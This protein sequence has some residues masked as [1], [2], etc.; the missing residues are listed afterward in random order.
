MLDD[1]MQRPLSA[2]DA[3]NWQVLILDGELSGEK[4]YVDSCTRVPLRCPYH[5]YS[6]ILVTVA[7]RLVLEMPELTLCVNAPLVIVCGRE[8][9]HIFQE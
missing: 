1:A 4:R 3:I 7:K 6:A 9:G 8:G 5:D 2:V